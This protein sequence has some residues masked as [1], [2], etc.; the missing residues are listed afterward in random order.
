MKIRIGNH[1]IGPG[2]KCFLIAEIGVNHNGSVSIA[3][4]LIQKAYQAGVDAVKFQ[5]FSADNLVT[6]DAPQ[7]KYQKENTKK[8]QTQYQLLKSLELSPDDHKVLQQYCQKLGVLFLSSPFDENAADLLE[9]LGVD[10]YKIPSG[11]ITNLPFLEYVAKKGKPIILSTGMSSMDEVEQAVEAIESGKGREIIL[12]QCTSNYPAK[13]EDANLR[14]MDA[15]RLMFG[16][17][18]GFSDHTLGCEIAIAAVAMGADV[19]EKH[20][21][22]DK[23]MDGP[24]HKASIEPDEL[25]YMVQSIRKIEAAFGDGHKIPAKDEDEIAK[26]VRKSIFARKDI[27][28]GETITQDSLLISRPGNGLPPSSLHLI[29]GKKAKQSIK[30]GNQITLEQ[31][32]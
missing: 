32:K 19:I 14:A 21:T 24:D 25:Q 8:K 20:F 5:T 23:A 13:P 2:E 30:A 27:A 31:I 12:L 1:I 7:A 18:V 3:K 4:E 9:N 11:E 29:V 10:A 16:F 22:L 15:M 28:V 26:L 6:K 17:P